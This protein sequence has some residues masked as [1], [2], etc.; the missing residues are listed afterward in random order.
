[1]QKEI[2]LKVLA[3]EF[4]I[5]AFV[6]FQVL[7]VEREKVE[8]ADG[9]E[10]NKLGKPEK[11]K[12][13]VDLYEVI[14]KGKD[15]VGSIKPYLNK[16]DQYYVDIFSKIAE[17]VEIQKNLMN[18]SEEEITA[19]DKAEIDKIGILKAIKPYIAEDKKVVV[20]KFLKFHEALKNLQQK[21]EKYSKEEGKDNIFD[22]IVDIYEAIKPIIPEDKMET[23]DKLAK[24][25]KLLEVLN[26]AEGI[27]NS[28]KEEK[29]QN[30]QITRSMP[31]ETEEAAEVVKLEEENLEKEEK[32]E[33]VY[34][35]QEQ[36]DDNTT[37]PPDL[38]EQQLAVID[39][40]KSMLTKEQ[41]QYMYNMINY[42]K[43]Q[44][45][46]NS[47]DKKEEKDNEKDNNS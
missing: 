1:M 13:N 40:L 31:D 23:A 11:D 47:A 9:K 42:L 37:L 8:V 33:E 18:L 34:E 19:M 43:Q 17:I 46:V 28:M 30:Q 6:R 12:I 25:I 35:Q 24:N 38:S 14:T 3:I 22:K 44:G 7:G 41:Q 20:D 15:F 16:R 36:D 27:M 5:I 4:L 32:K 26:K 21:M 45:L 2:L 29:E 10:K 39:N